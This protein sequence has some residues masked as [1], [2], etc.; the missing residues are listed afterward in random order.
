LIEDR[1]CGRPGRM[2]RGTDPII[3]WKGWNAQA[4]QPSAR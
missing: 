4:R 2:A 1:G 3:I